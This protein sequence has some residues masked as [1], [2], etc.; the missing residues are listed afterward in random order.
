MHDTD[1]RGNPAR[2]VHYINETYKTMKKT[3][4]FTMLAAALV[5]GHVFAADAILTEVKGAT[6]SGNSY[7]GERNNSGEAKDANVTVSASATGSDLHRASV[8]GG[9]AN[10]AA[11]NNKITMTG[12]EV[13]SLYGGEGKTTVSKN[14]VIMTG[15]K[16]TSSLRGGNSTADKTEL[17]TPLVEKNVAIVAGDCEISSGLYGGYSSHGYAKDNKVY[18]VGKGATATITDAQGITS[19]YKGGNITLKAVYA[20]QGDSTLDNNSIDNSLDIY[21]TGITA[22]GHVEDMQ[23][24]NFHISQN[25]IGGEYANAS[26][27]TLTSYDMNLTNVTI[28]IQDVDVQAWTPG[29]TVTLVQL[30]KDK[31]TI[32]GIESGQVVDIKRD[33]KVVAKGQLVL[34]NDNM[35]LSLSIP[36]SV[37]E[38]TTGTLSL[39]ALAGLCI[40]RR[41]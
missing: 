21:G 16:V 26:M 1:N 35:T 38:P 29:T 2:H 17:V 41:K 4:F 40:R 10:T 19:I 30:D 11:S 20:G 23:V 18:L 3:L 25:Q 6:Q 27:L 8:Y 24:L 14:T 39:L 32:K 12:G 36:G 13:L 7:Y 34:S 5:G 22:S 33:D 31:K 28:G 15:G 37:P 9:Y